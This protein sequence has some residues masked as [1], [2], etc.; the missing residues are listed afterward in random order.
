MKDAAMGVRFN[1]KRV[2]IAGGGIGG[3]TAALALLR[4]G[5]DVEVYE[6]AGELREVGAGFHVTPNAFR[7][8]H[9]IGIGDA[10]AA[11]ACI[12]AGREIRLW[13]T[14]EVW[15]LFQLGADAVEKY[16]FPYLTVYRPDLLAALVD[17]VLA[18][19]PDAIRL[20]SVCQGFDQDA[21]G[22]TLRHSQGVAHGDVLIGADGVHSRVRQLLFGGGESRYSG[23]VAWRGLIP[24]ERLP[25]RMRKPVT[26]TWIGPRGHF[27]H[28]PVHGGKFMN[29]VGNSE[30]DRDWREESWCIRG[31]TEECLTDFPG[32]HDDLKMLISRIDQPYKW[33]LMS[34]PPMDRWS[35]GAV[36]LL[37]DACHPTL[38]FLGQ[39]AC[40]A[41]ED[42]YILARALEAEEDV[43]EAL[44]RYENA[45][46]ERTARIVNGSAANADRYQ[47]RVLADTDTARE[48][49]AREFATDEVR[50][51]L[52]WI[53]A[54][55]VDEVPV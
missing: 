37:G 10:V 53:Y 27:V 50:G 43:P 52:D 26:S 4:R 44:R 8:L 39:G 49:V 6:Q 55:N 51:R 9:S 54:Y 30:S 28:Y 11:N 2:L 21:N 14:G 41:I 29:L 40:M 38:P 22:V 3:M 17:A 48:Y 1:S 42:G 19:K 20:H 24:M 33:A 12:A 32:W 34:R 13:S 25:D 7:V 23:L 46:R 5:F 15:S 31:T 16:G 45:R 18:I 35:D 47:N 36:T